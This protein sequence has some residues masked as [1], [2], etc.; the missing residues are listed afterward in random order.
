MTTVT[1]ATKDTAARSVHQ[2]T[3]CRPGYIRIRHYKPLCC[4]SGVE[5]PCSSNVRSRVEEEGAWCGGYRWYK[6]ALSASSSHLVEGLRIPRLVETSLTRDETRGRNQT[7]CL[8]PPY[9][10]FRIQPKALD[11]AW[12][13]I[14]SRTPPMPRWREMDQ[15]AKVELGA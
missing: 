12:W 9:V 5:L 2:L 6:Q 3:P 7:A 1:T 13:F 10:P 4:W 14:H 11:A 8:Y 15:L